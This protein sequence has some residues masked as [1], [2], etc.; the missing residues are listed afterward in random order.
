MRLGH[1]G[2]AL[3]EALGALGDG[4]SRD[5]REQLRRQAAEILERTPQGLQLGWNKRDFGGLDFKGPTLRAARYLGDDWYA[6]LALGSGRYRGDALDSSLLGS[7]RN[8]R[9]TL[10]RELADGFAAATFDGSWR[11]DED[12]HGLG[13]LRNWRLSSR[14]ELEAGL[15]W[16]RET[17]ETGLMR[18]LGMRDSLRLG[19]RHTLSGRDQLSWSLAHNRFSTRQGD[20]LGNGEALSLEWAHTLFFDGPAWQLRG[21]IDYQRNRLEN[22]LPDD[23][24]AAH[25]GALA[26]DGARSQDLLQDRYGQVYLGSTW[27]RGFPGALNRSRPQY[28][29]IVDTLAGWQWT[30]KEFNYGID[31]GIGMELLGDDELAFTFGYQSAP[32][33]G[34]GDAGGTLGVTYST[35]FGR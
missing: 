20:D 18:A 30:E 10:R 1:G 34:G 11:D 24:L 35:R 31:L 14:D 26:L 9:L 4:H 16:H 13:L 32:Q 29:W 17:D 8:A 2:E 6:D 3:G 5:N 22:R 23:L 15:D 25:G 19:G 33:G 12:R 28:T 27:R 21:G 7:E